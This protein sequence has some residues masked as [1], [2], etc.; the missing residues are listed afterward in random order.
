M[1]HHIKTFTTQLEYDEFEP[2]E[3]IVPR[4]YLLTL[5]PGKYVVTRFHHPLYAGDEPVVFVQN[6][7]FGLNPHE[8]KLE[9]DDIDA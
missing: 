3:I 9:N 1:K 5:P 4:Q 7:R 2:G 8:F 6:H